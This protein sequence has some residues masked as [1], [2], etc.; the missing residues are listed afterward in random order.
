LWDGARHRWVRTQD[1]D[2]NGKGH[3]TQFIAARTALRGDGSHLVSLGN[4][5][6][7]MREA[8]A[9]MKTKYKETVR[10]ASPST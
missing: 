2:G 10:G 8:R 9:D 7:M 4:V 5:I 6:T 3:L 1:G